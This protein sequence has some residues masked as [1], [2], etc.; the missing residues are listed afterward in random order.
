MAI[1]IAVVGLGP[2]GQEWVRNVRA[3]PAFELVA[4]VKAMP[5]LCWWHKTTATCGHF[6]LFD[7]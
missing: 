3:S 4:C 2:R 5:R 7:V 6:E 1:R